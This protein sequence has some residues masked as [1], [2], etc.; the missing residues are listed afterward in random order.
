MPKIGGPA[1]HL[2]CNAP[3][4]PSIYVMPSLTPSPIKDC[5]PLSIPAA[6]LSSAEEVDGPSPEIL[7]LQVPN[8]LQLNGNKD[9]AS[10]VFFDDPSSSDQTS[11]TADFGLG[12]RWHYSGKSAKGR[13]IYSATKSGKGSRSGGKDT[14]K[15]KRGHGS[16]WNANMDT[17]KGRGNGLYWY[18]IGKG[19]YQPTEPSQKQMNMVKWP[20]YLPGGPT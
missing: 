12:H 5:P 11:H 4:P 8:M 6:M 2:K 9:V 15:G 18:V 14:S 10:T 19:G 1:G 7:Q 16:R 17:G 13:G 3:F 20:I